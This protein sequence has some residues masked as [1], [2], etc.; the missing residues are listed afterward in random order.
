[1]Q[2]GIMKEKRCKCQASGKKWTGKKKGGDWAACNKK[3]CFD[4]KKKILHKK[5]DGYRERLRKR[6][7]S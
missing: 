6:T 4:N 5:K 1:M 7:W 2:K 3:K